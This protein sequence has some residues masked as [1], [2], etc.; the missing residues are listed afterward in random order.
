[1]LVDVVDET[2]LSVELVE[3]PWVELP[4]VEL[5]ETSLALSLVVELVVDAEL[6]SAQA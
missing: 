5:V 3:L 6:I 4:R 1:M 2:P